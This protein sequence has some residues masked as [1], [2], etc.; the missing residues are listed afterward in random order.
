MKQSLL[1]FF[2]ALI[3]SWASAQYPVLSVNDLQF[4]D[5]NDLVNCNDSSPYFGDTVTT[6]GIVIADGNIMEIASGS[7]DGGYR[8]EVYIL[9]TAAGGI[10]SSFNMISVH[11]VYPNPNQGGSANLPVS[12]MNNL[13]AGT[14]VTVTGVMSRFAGQTQL[15]PIN[16]SAVVS[17]TI[18]LAPTAVMV[19]LGQLN[20]DQRVNQLE[21]GEQWENAFIEIQNVT[22]TSVNF[23]NGGSRVSFDVVDQNGNA[24]NVSD[25]FLAQK[26]PSHTTVNP[27]SPL[28]TGSFVAPPVG[29]V[30]SSIRGIVLHS[31]NGCTGEAGRGYEINPFD[32]SHYD[33]GVAPP[34]IT[35]ITRNPGQPTSADV[36]TVEA[37]ITDFDGTVTDQSLF[38]ATD[39]A[40]PFASFTEVPMTLKT[41]TTDEFE[42]DIPASADG[43]LVRYYITADDNDNNTSV[44]PFT[45]ASQTQENVFWYN[46][47]DNG[48]TIRDIQENINPGAGDS[49]YN[50]EEVTF[51][52][53]VSASTRAFDLGF[54]YVQDENETE[55]AGVHCTGNPD[56]F[57][58][59]RGDEVEITGIVQENFGFTLVNVTNV[60][61][62]GTSRVSL[63]PVTLDPSDNV[64]D[65][66]K[67]ESMLVQFVNPTGKVF[68]SDDDAGFAD[69]AIS[70]DAAN[71]FD[72]STLVQAG[73]QDN[74]NSSSLWV[75]L[76]SDSMWETTDGEMEVPVVLTSVANEMDTLR[77]VMYYGFGNYKLLPR[78]NADIIGLNA[79][80]EEV[81]ADT[82]L[83]PVGIN[84]FNAIKANVQVYPNPANEQVFVAHDLNE[85]VFLSMTD[86]S[87]RA[88]MNTQLNASVNSI[89]LNDLQQG[90]YVMRLVDQQGRLLKASKLIV[91]H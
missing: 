3:T 20:D 89:S 49:P 35:N 55:W 82:T 34:T 16:N 57:T 81:A 45:P 12:V 2:F 60:N 88:I 37:T 18:G 27:A 13:I 43:T 67:Y 23:F 59:Y 8:P 90:I 10:I 19:D 85:V 29:T 69:Y 72:N 86:I 44:A 76:V 73:R 75:S 24:I 79:T 5:Q 87:G 80:L 50:G 21:T 70:T 15:N 77:G 33:I 26:L 47:R 78:N 40:T 58:L 64:K 53:I 25:R 38:Y 1:L 51:T 41:G 46:V 83:R 17:N 61:Y 14:E 9:D 56:L 4:V 66:E 62:T 30:Y 52:G 74:S 11:G 28:A 7:T 91:T 63:T 39:P 31:E 6:T 54:V 22:V 36:V 84:D 32:A 42:G 48:L 68:I 71:D 65:W